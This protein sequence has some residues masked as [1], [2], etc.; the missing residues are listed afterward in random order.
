MESHSRGKQEYDEYR[1][2]NAVKQ[3][4]SGL[5]KLRIFVILALKEWFKA[6]FN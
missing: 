5:G 4:K 2:R 6:K 1:M 3:E